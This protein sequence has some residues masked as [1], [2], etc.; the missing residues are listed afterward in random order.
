MV[1]LCLIVE[2]DISDRNKLM[3]RLFLM[4]GKVVTFGG[5]DHY[6][7]ETPLMFSRCSSL[8]SLS[9]F[10]QHSIHDDRS[11]VVSDFR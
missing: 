9:S 10:E 3:N 2:E 1:I 5:A 8:G 11:S 4:S 6:A 7:E